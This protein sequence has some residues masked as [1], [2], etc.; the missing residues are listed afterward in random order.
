MP[1]VLSANLNPCD[2]VRQLYLA[3]DRP[4][5]IADDEHSESRAAASR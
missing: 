5:T 1:P 2:L 3:L 4:A